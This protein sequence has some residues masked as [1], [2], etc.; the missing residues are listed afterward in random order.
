[1]VKEMGWKNEG[2]EEILVIAEN[3]NCSSDGVQFTTGCSLGNNSLIFR[4]LGKIAFTITNRN[5]KGIRLSLKENTMENLNRNSEYYSL[6]D[7]VIKNRE[8]NDKDMIKFK[9]LA[10]ETAFRIIEKDAE[11]LFTVEPVFTKI[12]QYAPIQENFICSICKEKTM[13]TRGVK[14]NGEKLCFTCANSGYFELNGFGI[15]KIDSSF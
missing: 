1:M 7:K 5:G 14:K 6:F 10:K 2:M 9:Q 8:G 12:P 11:N 3:N 13:M 15:Q 4:D